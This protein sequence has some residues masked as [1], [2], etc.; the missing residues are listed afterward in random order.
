[1]KSTAVAVLS[2]LSAVKLVSEAVSCF[3]SCLTKSLLFRLAVRSSS[4]SKLLV[5]WS[6]L[7]ISFMEIPLARATSICFC[8]SPNFL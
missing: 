3:L 1:M 5:R 7:R 6:K 8:T 2:L 4:K